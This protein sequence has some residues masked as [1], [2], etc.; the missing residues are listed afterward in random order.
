MRDKRINGYTRLE[1]LEARAEDRMRPSVES[2]Q[3]RM[4]RYQTV[5]AQLKSGELTLEDLP[6]NESVGYEYVLDRYGHL[7]DSGGSLAEDS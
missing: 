4:R 5:F 6:P 1:R 3:D 7:Y 2:S